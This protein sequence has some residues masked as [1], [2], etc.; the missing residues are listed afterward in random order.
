[1]RPKGAYA[2]QLSHMLARMLCLTLLDA[3]G[4]PAILL[5]AA[6]GRRR[7]RSL[8]I[9]YP[10]CQLCGRWCEDVSPGGEG[11]AGT[12]ARVGA[13]ATFMLGRASHGRDVGASVVAQSAHASTRRRVRGSAFDC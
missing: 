5:R 8:Q 4:G 3:E 1:M 9:V 2:C 6:V 13:A 11:P 7:Y 10:L 12:H